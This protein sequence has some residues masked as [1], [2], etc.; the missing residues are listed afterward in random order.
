MSISLSSRFVKQARPAFGAS[1]FFAIALFGCKKD[2]QAGMSG[3]YQIGQVG[4]GSGGA[5][6][7]GAPAAGGAAPGGAAGAAGAATGVGGAPPPSGPIAQKLDPSAG[8]AIRP[9]LDQAAKDQTQPGAK[10]V[11]ETLV[12]NF[13]TGQTLDTQILLQPNKC[14]TVVATALPPVT[15]VNVQLV[16]QTPMP[17]M[18]PVL[19]VD[20]DSGPTAVLGKKATCYKWMF[21]TIPASAKVV[22]QVTGGSGLVA[23]QTY[24]K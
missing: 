9:L 14:Y 10:P 5:P 24:E 17:G 22:V 16:L 6:T 20:Q 12:G 7:Y 19:A 4:G 18:T 8:A 11:G 2:D 23:A 3:G 13:G 1:V 15:E 21:G